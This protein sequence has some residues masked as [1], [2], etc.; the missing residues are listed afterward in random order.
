MRRGRPR[1]SV[2]RRRRS[3][4]TACSP[5]PHERDGLRTDWLVSFEPTPGTVAFFGYGSSLAKDPL[6]YNT[7]AYTRTSDGFFVKL[8]YRSE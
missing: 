7:P 4:S 3:T 1:G 5:A 2:H 8:A 6:L